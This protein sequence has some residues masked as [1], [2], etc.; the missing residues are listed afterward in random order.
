MVRTMFL[1]GVILAVAS[2]G[3]EPAEPEKPAVTPEAPGVPPDVVRD[4][5]EAA[6]PA[7]VPFAG[8]KLRAEALKAGVFDRL[9]P[10]GNLGAL[11]SAFAGLK[12]AAAV[13]AGREV[14]GPAGPSI[15]PSPQELRF[16]ELTDRLVAALA[17]STPEEAREAW[18]ATGLG[19]DPLEGF[20]LV[21][22][23]AKV[24][25]TGYV[26]TVGYEVVRIPPP[27]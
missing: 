12:T 1:L 11:I 6:V 14:G 23:T 8:S 24:F 27:K 4:F 21:T 9:P 13:S 17:A 2:C 5:E 18:K 16:A 15:E 10:P 3:G 19:E 7:P 20:T 26:E 25:G 22:T